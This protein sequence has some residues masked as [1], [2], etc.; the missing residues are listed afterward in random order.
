MRDIILIVGRCLR[1][2]PPSQSRNRTEFLE[3]IESI[4]VALRKLRRTKSRLF[5]WGDDHLGVHRKYACLLN[6]P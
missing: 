4:E 2:F 5:A 1:P 6:L 3:R